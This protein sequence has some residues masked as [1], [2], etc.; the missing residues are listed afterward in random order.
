MYNTQEWKKLVDEINGNIL[1]NDK[2]SLIFQVPNDPLFY[3]VNTS[4]PDNHLQIEKR[5]SIFPDDIICTHS[6]DHERHNVCHL[7]NTNYQEIIKQIKDFIK[8]E[9]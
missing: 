9:Q 2:E 8:M 6:I 3:A 5:N 1:H 4:N 7:T